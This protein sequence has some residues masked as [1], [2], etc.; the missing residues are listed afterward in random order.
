[1]RS[2]ERESPVSRGRQSLF[3]CLFA[4]FLFSATASEA[5][6]RTWYI[7]ADGTGDAATIQAGV[8]SATAGDIVLVAP[9]SYPQ[10]TSMLVDGQMAS[11]NVFIDHDITLLAEG[12]PDNT[13]IDGSSG[14][15]TVYVVSASAEIRGFEVV[16][17]FAGFG[18]VTGQEA[19]QW[20]SQSMYT[21]DACIRSDSA[22]VLIV[23][24]RIHG[25]IGVQL[26]WTPL[27]TVRN[28]EI[29]NA[30]HGI[31]CQGGSDA[32]TSEN[33]IH[34]CGVGVTCIDSSPAVVDSEIRSDP[35]FFSCYGVFA[36]PGSPYVSGNHIRGMR[37]GGI[38]AGSSSPTIENNLIENSAEGIQLSGCDGARIAGN[39]VTLA[40]WGIN[41]IDTQNTV[42]ENNSIIGSPSVSVGILCQVFTTN[43]L[44]QNNIVVAARGV[45]CV[46]SPSPVFQCNNIVAPQR[47]FGDCSDQTGING[48]IS[49][50][51]QFCGVDGS[52]NYYL[53]S[54]SPCAPG[55][56]PDGYDC[57]LIG[58]FG[59]GCETVP[60]KD[61]TWGYIK[62]LFDE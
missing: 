61:R 21:Q 50:D 28:N 54:A 59:L 29:Y 43:P 49:M 6:C 18:C 60:T 41:L 42:V 39:I 32:T 44:I 7:K 9:G 3:V 23:E 62:S 13:T 33:I 14:D 36:T 31:W 55:N 2:A 37:N 4:A 26:M 40:G 52:G 5:L 56:H 53:Q 24:N 38:F 12:S 10:S 20:M 48:N 22:N 1:M 30:V 27:A 16:G 57:G 25:R 34:G 46:N 8:D 19:G 58:A 47:Y 45:E 35:G 15:I 17:S 51:P 11:V